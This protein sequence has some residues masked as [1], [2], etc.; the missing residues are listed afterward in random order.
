M[1]LDNCLMPRGAAVPDL[2]RRF[3]AGCRVHQEKGQ[4]A[5]GNIELALKTSRRDLH[6]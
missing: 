3:L 5:E 2:V 1:N 4:K 6:G